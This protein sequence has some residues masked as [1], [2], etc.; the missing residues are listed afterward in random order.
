M[1]NTYKNILPVGS[2]VH[3]SLRIEDLLP[4]FLFALEDVD[5][6]AA[7]RFGFELIELGFGYSQCGVCFGPREEWPNVDDETLIDIQEEIS[8]KLNEYVPAGCYF[9]AHEGDGSDFGVWGISPKF[10][11]YDADACSVLR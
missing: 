6:V 3:G 4:A 2:I 7:T 9:G 11:E 10:E 5:A 1:I 8:D